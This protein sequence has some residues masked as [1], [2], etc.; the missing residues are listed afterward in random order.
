MDD[1]KSSFMGG[2]NKKQVE[3]K[4]E[5]LLKE[6][7]S[8]KSDLKIMQIKLNE[9]NAGLMSARN[10][11]CISLDEEKNALIQRVAEL[12]KQLEVENKTVVRKEN[13]GTIG[14]NKLYMQAYKSAGLITKEA[15]E[16]VDEYLIVLDK[17]SLSAKSELETAILKYDSIKEEI[18]NLLNHITNRISEVSDKSDD[19]IKKAESIKYIYEALEKTKTSVKSN[20]N[21]ILNEFNQYANQFIFF[22]ESM[23]KEKSEENIEETENIL[24]SL[25]QK[26]TQS[27]ANETFA[28]ID[29]NKTTEIKNTLLKYQ[30]K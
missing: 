14:I 4:I 19:L 29:K 10:S 22:D 13:N 7:E 15:A 24:T 21:G 3:S 11:D 28:V 6:N 23:D 25:P 20:S 30:K 17:A 18:N 9:A 26:V 5:S 12:E 2:Y 16:K 8:L 1:L 27:N